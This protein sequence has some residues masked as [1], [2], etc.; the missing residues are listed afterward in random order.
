MKEAAKV[1]YYCALIFNDKEHLIAATEKGL[2]FV[3]SPNTGLV[4]LVVWIEKNREGTLLEE[5]NEFMES[6]RIALEE[7]FIGERHEFDVPL[8]VSGTNFQESVWREL[9]N[10]LYGEIKTYAEIAEAIGNPK[11]VRAVASAIGQNPVMIVVP[12]HRVIR[13]NGM[14]SGYRGGVEMKKDLLEL[15]KLR[16]CID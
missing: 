6:Y 3:G 11:A 12:C 16:S 4:E 2:A 13:K 9:V 15:E 1:M 14:I 7:Y 8:D 5:N 10:I